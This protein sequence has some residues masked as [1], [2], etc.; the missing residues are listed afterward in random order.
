MDVL[1]ITEGTEYVPISWLQYCIQCSSSSK[2]HY[3]YDKR[4]FAYIHYSISWFDT[5]FEVNSSQRVRLLYKHS[6]SDSNGRWFALPLYF[7]IEV[8]TLDH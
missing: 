6:G 8:A 3:Q 7:S 5:N 4:N 1:N 2:W